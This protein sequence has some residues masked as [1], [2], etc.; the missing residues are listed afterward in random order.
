MPKRIL[1]LRIRDFIEHIPDST[2]ISIATKT[3]VGAGVTGVYSW[4]SSVNWIGV[5]SALVAVIG[6]FTN[7]YFQ[8]R[9]DKREH[10]EHIER[11]AQMR[12]QCE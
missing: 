8:R 7:F 1:K 5:I 12:G 10:T 11:L 6:L 4:I 2:A 3:T 9:R